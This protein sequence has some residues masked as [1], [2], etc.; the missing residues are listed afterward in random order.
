[1]SRARANREPPKPFGMCRCG[2]LF[3]NSFAFCTCK[4]ASH[5]HI[6]QQLK[7][8]C[9]QRFSR[10]P[11]LTPVVSA[12]VQ[13]QGGRYPC[14]KA[15]SGLLPALYRSQL[16]T[17]NCRL[18]TARWSLAPMRDQSLSESSDWTLRTLPEIPTAMFSSVWT[19]RGEGGRYSAV[20]AKRRRAELAPN[21]GSQPSVLD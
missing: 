8:P 15:K 5:L 7:A 18:S 17:L 20:K 21:L 9:F 12:L 14:L 2:L 3:G 10:F 19:L 1:M 13:M 4:N 11:G 6:P 16:S